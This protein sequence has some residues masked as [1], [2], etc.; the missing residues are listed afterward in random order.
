ML[1]LRGCRLGILFPEIVE[2]Q[3]RAIARAAARLKKEGKNPI[4]EIMVPLVGTGAEMALERQRLEAVVKDVFAAEGVRC[5]C[6]IGTMVELPRACLVADK[7]AENAEFF[8]FGTNDLTQTTFGY[9]RDDAEGKFLSEYLEQKILP[10]NPF[11]SLDREGVG[12]LMQHRH[13]ARS[14]AA[15]GPGD[16]HLR[17]ARRR[18][19]VGRVLPRAWVELRQLRARAR[20]DRAPGGG[21]G[22]ARVHARVTADPFD[23]EAR[24]HPEVRRRT[25]EREELLASS[26]SRSRDSRDRDSGRAARSDAHGVPGRPRSH[27]PLEG[28]PPPQAQDAG[29][30]R[31][32]WR[33]LPHA[34]DAHHGGDAG[35]ALDR[36]RAQPERGPDRGDCAGPRPGPHAVRACRRIRPG[37]V[38]A[39]RVP[40]QRAERARGRG[41][42]KGWPRAQPHA[43]KCATAS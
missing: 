2:M 14:Q 41:A 25:E 35:R 36:A 24:A 12:Q 1:G 43:A 7:L 4:P 32:R 9:S 23:W 17:R 18:P 27:H 22:G 30:H 39:A 8:S 28:V 13:R 19:G 37:D 33:P 34:P 16:R 15:A 31:P 3:V 21:A 10:V 29:L 11:E 42:R 40:P 38:P 6:M 5:A 20:A 26:P